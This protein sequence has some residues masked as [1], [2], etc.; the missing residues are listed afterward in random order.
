MVHY[1]TFRNTDPP[2]LVEVWNQVFTERGAALLAGTTML[3]YHVFAKP[4][5]DREGLIF[6]FDDARPVGFAHA[7]FG[8]NQEH[9]ALSTDTGVTCMVGVIPD[10]RRQGIGRELLQR[11]EAYLRG[12]GARDLFVGPAPQLNPFYLGLYGSSD[13]A[14]VLTN[15]PSAD[16]FLVRHGYRPVETFEVWQRRLDSAFAVNDWRFPGHRRKYDIRIVPRTGA[17]SWWQECVQGPLEVVEFRLEEK[18]TGKTIAFASAWDME[19]FSQR[20][21]EAAVGIMRIEVQ[22]DSRRQ[23]LAKFLVD[24]LLRHLQD[25]CFL[26]AEVVLSPNDTLATSLFQS[27][28]FQQ[29]DVGHSYRRQSLSQIGTLTSSPTSA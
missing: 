28:G 24:L 9:K 14:G 11:S 10:Y 20:W 21:R 23:G 26:R 25:Q 6:A 4:Y 17:L 2:H 8:P 27:L 22:E 3:E 15:D 18:L 5:F 16:P 13:S 12:R 1:R 29:V 7:G 19:S